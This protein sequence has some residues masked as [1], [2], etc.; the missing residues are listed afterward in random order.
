M[1]VGMIEE[2][3]LS[4]PSDDGYHF[5]FAEREDGTVVGYACHWR[6]SLTESAY[7]LGWIAVAPAHR[8]QGVAAGL[9]RAVED[10]VARRGGG[11]ILIETASNPTYEGTR[12][13]YQSQDYRVVARIP[14]LYRAGDDC[15]IY[16]K[17]V[18][19]G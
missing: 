16:R 9:M 19:A 6:R 3:L 1:A 13:F 11:Q 17:V 8:R 5:T 18:A 12:E 15:L 4:G 7:D 14:D 10:G 2:T